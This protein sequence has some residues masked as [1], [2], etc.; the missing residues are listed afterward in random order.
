VGVTPFTASSK[1]VVATVGGGA[2]GDSR[3]RRRATLVDS[4]PGAMVLIAH[5]LSNTGGNATPTPSRRP[6]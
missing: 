6:T 1:T 3:Q 4:Q 5:T 2:G